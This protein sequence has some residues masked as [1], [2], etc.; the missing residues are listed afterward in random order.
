MKYKTWIALH[1]FIFQKNFPQRKL[2][3][4]SWW[5]LSDISG[6][7]NTTVT[8]TLS[9]NRRKGNTSHLVWWGQRA[10]EKWNLTVDQPGRRDLDQAIKAN[11]TNLGTNGHQ[12][13]LDTTPRHFCGILP[14]CFLESRQG[15][16][17]DKPQM[18]DILQNGCPASFKNVNIMKDKETLRNCSRIKEAEEKNTRKCNTGSRIF[19]YCKRH[20]WDQ[21]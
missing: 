14:I 15:E 9:E 12:V 18:R 17:S 19:F 2:Q 11:V 4:A 1:R 10:K 6:S 5:S 7:A 16:A 13:P 20:Y 21:W 3:T 8:Q